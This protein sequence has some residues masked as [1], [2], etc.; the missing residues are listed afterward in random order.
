MQIDGTDAGGV[1]SI[2]NPPTLAA[3]AV[4]STLRANRRE[5]V[6]RH[7]ESLEMRDDGTVRRR[8]TVEFELPPIVWAAVPVGDPILVPLALRSKDAG[9]EVDVRDENGARVALLPDSWTTEIAVAGLLAVA[10]G[11]GVSP[12]DDCLRRT[13]A[14]V[15]DGA[16]G[17]AHI[18]LGQLALGRSEELRRVWAHEPFREAARTLADHR[19]LLVA[20]R[21]GDRPRT[22]TYSHDDHPLPVA[23]AAGEGLE[24]RLAGWLGWEG[25][26][27]RVE[28]PHL[29]DSETHELEVDAGGA[30]P[31]VEI[32]EDA[33]TA[34][35]LITAARAHSVVWGPVAGLLA[36][37]LL[38]IGWLA[39]PGFEGRSSPL[40]VLL[41]VP[42]VLAAY[43]ARRPD[44]AAP[45]ELVRG[46]RSL[47]LAVAAVSLL[48][49]AALASGASAP[50]LRV[51]CGVLSAFA[52]AAAALLVETRR[53]AGGG[54]PLTL[55]PLGT[56]RGP[57]RDARRPHATRT[58]LLA[59]TMAA[60]LMVVALADVAARDGS[61]ADHLLF[62]TGLL[63]IYLPAVAHAWSGPP[64][65]E[66]VLG[67][68][69][70]GVALYLVKVLHSPLHFTFHDEFSTLRTTVD[71]ERSG[72]LFERN[73]LIEVHPFYPALEL[74][75]SAL[76]SVTGLSLFV[77]GLI[78]IGVLRVALMAALF[79]VFESAVST[80]VAALAT[81]LYACN[82][83]FV[84]FDS[85]WA[86][87]SF[88]LPL[89]LVAVAMAAQGRRTAFLAIPVVIT[90]CMSHPLTSIALICFFGLWAAF[91]R[92][93][94]A[95]GG[96]RRRDELWILAGAGATFLALWALL[97]ARS[98]GG[99][100][101][102]VLGDAG[103]SLVDL[104]L[105]ES[106]PKRIFG[107]AGV[108][109]TPLLE[110]AL[111]F[112]AVLLA[113]AAVGLGVRAVWRRYTPLAGALVAA[114]LVYPLSLPLRLTEAGTEISNRASE[115]VFV[116]VALLGAVVLYERRFSR[117]AT[118]VVV[119]AAAVGLMGGVVIGTAR[120]ARLPGEYLVVADES[121]V[122]PEGRLAAQWARHELGPENRIF[123]DRI[124]GLL[125]GSLGLQDPQV[126][127]ILGRPVPILFT[128]PTVD[129]DVRLVIT[130]DDIDHLVVDKRLATASPTVG[131]YVER[132]E[133]GA[134]RHERPLDA[135]A[136]L[137]YDLVC[138]VGRAF[139]SGSLVVYDTRRMAANDV[140]PAARRGEPA[141]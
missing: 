18:A 29:K 27:A 46:V 123:T 37:V 73:P 122:E 136:L 60:G 9:A 81:V 130:A 76:S 77:S 91:D 104:L 103:E 133:P 3:G 30:E 97:V 65:A 129:E 86:Y 33:G 113:L 62:W 94:V 22:L 139:D 132:E 89:A 137:K 71:I 107:A 24:R 10:R 98:L 7:A 69:L 44:P 127:T 101:G 16:P 109:D 20:L 50:V 43:L 2:V 88:A 85:Q 58:A 96:G 41:G 68:V 59:C 120:H 56:A 14:R 39:A 55:A 17:P 40:L 32:D 36:A 99:Y 13:V 21:E 75:T 92:W 26:R 67:V 108:A 82:P 128:R 90:L 19:M 49:E 64:R 31:A 135:A 126:G 5:W 72:A 78:V 116:G 70:A 52:W 121:S 12:D 53:R 118:P 48:A 141:P 131:F 140:C 23:T 102:P 8:V 28:L 57:E 51:V 11:A 87:E 4:V 134:Y 125:M 42:A 100:L 1:D 124:N 114:A 61:G 35:V 34:N 119:A 95:R 66:G 83:N 80:R 84:F 117:F 138:P 38:S 115:F 15:V 110:R 106:G 45:P 54:G 112:G 111:G 63:A 25:C 93:T 105:G 79:L 47:L 6:R 74:V